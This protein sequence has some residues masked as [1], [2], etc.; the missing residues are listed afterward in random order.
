MK[1][2][3]VGTVMQLVV[4][5]VEEVMPTNRGASPQWVL[6]NPQANHLVLPDTATAVAQMPVAE[7]AAPDRAME[8]QAEEE[9]RLA[10]AQ[11]PVGVMVAPAVLEG[12]MTIALA[13]TFITA[14]AGAEALFILSPEALAVLE[15]A[16]REEATVLDCLMMARL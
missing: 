3:V 7:D 16:G 2:L 5:V 11:M 6:L 13:L 12:P 14:A 9:E 8:A 4:V 1:L 15:V 10:V